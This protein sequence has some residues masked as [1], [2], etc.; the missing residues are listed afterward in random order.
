MMNNE[1]SPKQFLRPLIASVISAFIVCVPAAAYA[2][3]LPALTTYTSEATWR[4]SVANP[5]LID[6][7]NL[8]DGT[9]VTSQY[10]GV[11]FSPFNGGTPLAA[12]EAGPLSLP[13]V[14]S[15]DN[16]AL[17]EGGGVSIG[18]AS[19]QTGMGFWYNDAQFAG[20]TVTVYGASNQVLGTFELVYPHPTEWQ[21]VGFLSSG[22]DITKVEIAMADMDRVTLD[23]VQFASPPLPTATL[24]STGAAVPGTSGVFTAFPQSPAL[25]LGGAAFLGAGSAG[26]FGVY[27]IPGEPVIPG[28]PIRIADL[29][30][31]IPGGSGR[32]T[33][34]TDL[35]LAAAPQDPFRV[36]FLGAGSGQAGVYLFDSAIPTDPIRIADL[37]TLIPGGTG[38]FTGFTDLALAAIPQDP[39]RVAFL[40]QGAGQAGVYLYDSAIPS[41]PFRIADLSTLI[42]GG[43]GSFTGFI[44]LALAAIPNEPIRVA[45]TGTGAGQ[46]GVYLYDS[47]IPSDPVRIADLA[48]LI[49][50]GTGSFTG[51]NAVSVSSEHTAFLGLGG[52]GQKGI[53]LASTLSKVIAVGDRLAGKT[54]TDL[55]FGRDG[56]SG[57]HLAFTAHFADGSEGVFAVQVATYP[58]A[59]FFA[60]VDNPPVFNK[61]KAGA[62]IPVKFSLNGNQGL[63][64]FAPGFPKSQPI[65]CDAAAAVDSIETTVA[66][67]VSSLTYDATS[68]QY[69]YVWKTDK[70][71]ANSCRE[72]LLQLNDGTQHKANFNFRLK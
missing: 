37:S 44:D 50:G 20:N 22:N 61:V 70:A 58:F 56:L 29:T 6:F 25:D 2:A 54:V 60:P 46:A 32:F 45:F 23:N 12:A 5:T 64:I 30:T 18:F 41:D 51:F 55:R 43:T 3:T 72:L 68:G 15:V 19:P 17:G 49:P 11:G 38:S 26:S 8:A 28:D 14:L 24:S 53:Y 4:S 47:A 9:A 35:A 33:G 21:F 65:A 39:F 27:F 34:F 7:D 62:A 52:T 48:T 40:G 42:P 63:A 36:A 16:L 31:L 69:T 13:N 57:I 1:Q 71:W 67:G 59:G 10:P 66:V